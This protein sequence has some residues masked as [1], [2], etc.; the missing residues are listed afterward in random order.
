M[1]NYLTQPRIQRILDEAFASLE[2][3]ALPVVDDWIAFA[4]QM[5]EP[6][7]D[8]KNPGPTHGMILV[9]N[10]VEAVDR[11]GTKSHVWL[12]SMVHE[13]PDGP[14]IFNGRELAVQGEIT[15]FAHPGDIPLRNLTH[16]RPAVP[17]EWEERSSLIKELA[18]SLESLAT[19]YGTSGPG[20]PF[21]YPADHRIS[22]ARAVL[23]KVGRLS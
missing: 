3:R 2:A 1:P 10:N 9:T 7:Y 18:D 16:W 20:R 12:V 14:H 19:F 8:S 22:I 6:R 23:A 5:P 17:E 21:A 4:D 13:H 11:W 15:A